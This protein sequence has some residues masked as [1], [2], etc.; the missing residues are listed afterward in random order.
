MVG[1]FFLPTH[2]FVDL[3]CPLQ[4]YASYKKD[5][6][7][8]P[9]KNSLAKMRT[10]RSTRELLLEMRYKSSE[11]ALSA[12]TSVLA[13][14]KGAP[15]DFEDLNVYTAPRA[16]MDLDHVPHPLDGC[17]SASCFGSDGDFSPT[18]GLAH[19]V[20]SVA[21]NG[22]V[23]GFGEAYFGPLKLTGTSTY[24]G[25]GLPIFVDLKVVINNADG[26]YVFHGTHNSE[27][28]TVTGSW[29]KV[30]RTQE[31]APEADP[32]DT[33]AT[34]A[35]EGVPDA[36]IRDTKGVQDA[37]V[38]GDDNSNSI[39]ASKKS[40]PDA[41]V[42]E[43]NAQQTNVADVPT[44]EGTIGDEPNAQV[45]TEKPTQADIAVE[46]TQTSTTPG[47][48]VNG[49]LRT[50]S[51]DSTHDVTRSALEN[52]PPQETVN[53]TEGS[54]DK[55]S[56]GDSDP[57]TSETAEDL[58]TSHEVA[59][60][61]V[62]VQTAEDSGVKKEESPK[63][64]NTFSMRRTPEHLHRFRRNLNLDSE[65]DPSVLA[66]NRWKFAI[67]STKFQ[68]QAR[69]M[70]WEYIRAR[71]AERRLWLDLAVAFWQDL[72]PPDRIDIMC[73]LTVEYP[74]SQSRLY[75]TIANFLNDRGYPFKT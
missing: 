26:D 15:F 13:L 67:E 61:A 20:L 66:K 35:Q 72:L 43:V 62:G 38:P 73:V 7:I 2:P 68:V 24:S 25:E 69:N 33:G 37:I 55:K 30:E 14:E 39:A 46:D 1:Q 8:S 17:W 31:S 6:E 19:F 40:E 44:N 9:A 57:N 48:I 28:D 51:N 34:G 21:P 47:D 10:K 49:E 59:E 12:D 42:A 58:Q 74:P 18:L 75:E 60:T 5:T 45:D 32:L 70:S 27:R 3:V 65:A 16:K 63:T 50:A 41:V 53:V 56:A 23:T 11:A 36:V 54:D 52:D 64:L 71:F 4:F 29:D 22:S